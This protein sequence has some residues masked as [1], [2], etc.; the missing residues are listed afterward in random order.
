MELLLKF[1]TNSEAETSSLGE[2]LRNNIAISEYQKAPCKNIKRGANSI[3]RSNRPVFSG[4]LAPATTSITVDSPYVYDADI[5]GFDGGLDLISNGY[6]KLGLL[7]SYRKGTY[8]YEED[9]DQYEIIGQAETTINSYL[10]GAYLRH[11]GQ[12]WSTIL[13]GYAGMI[14]ADISTEDDV[15]TSTSG[16]IY[17]ATLDVSYNQLATIDLSNKS[18]IEH[19][20]NF[21][22]CPITLNSVISINHFSLG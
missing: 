18:K 3:C 6:T 20:Y 4:W 17:G 10:A 12:N 22:F 11:D 1:Q 9:G 14:D 5:G 7:A 21:C 16:T 8:N 15:N 19:K 2:S 13:A